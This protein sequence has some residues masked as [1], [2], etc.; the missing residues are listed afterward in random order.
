MTDKGAYI[1]VE[2]EETDLPK[3]L[4][5]VR[6]QQRPVRILSNGHAVA[7][8][9]PVLLKRFGPPDP[10]LRAKILVPGHEITTEADWPEESR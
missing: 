3:L 1:T 9:A 2:V 6:Q 4:E 10:K 8:I 7:E 5:V